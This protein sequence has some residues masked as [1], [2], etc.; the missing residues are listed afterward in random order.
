MQQEIT[1]NEI[2]YLRSRLNTE[3][4]FIEVA[5]LQKELAEKEIM[6]AEQCRRRLEQIE[7]DGNGTIGPK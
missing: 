3:L 5:K 6:F 7:K 1:P 4:N 2:E